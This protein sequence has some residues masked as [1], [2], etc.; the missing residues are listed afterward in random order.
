M[1]NIGKTTEEFR[2]A[3]AV[4]AVVYRIWRG[5]EIVYVGINY[6]DSKQTAYKTVTRHFQNHNDRRQGR[7][8]VKDRAGAFVDFSTPTTD[9]EELL[10]LEAAEVLQY[11]PDGNLEFNS[12]RKGD[13]NTKFKAYEGLLDFIDAEADITP[14]EVRRAKAIEEE[15]ARLKQYRRETKQETEEDTE[16]WEEFL[17][18]L[19]NQDEVPF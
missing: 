18:G 9:E 13:R 11:K 4:T 7:Y 14:K 15:E 3:T 6:P 12:G 8:V 10:A 17:K 1:G 5:D 2:N 19:D 16:S